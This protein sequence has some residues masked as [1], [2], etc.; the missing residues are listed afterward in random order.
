MDMNTSYT[1][2]DIGHCKTVEDLPAFLKTVQPKSTKKGSKWRLGKN[3]Q[4]MGGIFQY[5][6]LRSS[7]YLKIDRVLMI[8]AM[9]F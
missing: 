6:H 8:L 2:L 1:M 3:R 7:Y 9:G 5:H 4:I